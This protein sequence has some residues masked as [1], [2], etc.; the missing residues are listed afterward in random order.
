MARLGY[1][2][3]QSQMHYKQILSELERIIL[4]KIKIYYIRV[5]KKMKKNVSQQRTKIKL[6]NFIDL[7][8]FFA[9]LNVANVAFRLLSDLASI[10]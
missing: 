1:V 6:K 10:Y 5:K 4:L 2:F 3:W 7:F 9:T 8:C